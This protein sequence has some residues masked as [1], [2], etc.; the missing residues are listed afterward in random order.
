MQERRTRHG[1]SDTKK[2]SHRAEGHGTRRGH[3]LA[4]APRRGRTPPPITMSCRTIPPPDHDAVLIT[5]WD[6]VGGARDGSTSPPPPRRRRRPPQTPRRDAA[7]G[8]G[9]KRGRSSRRARLDVPSMA[10]SDS[11]GVPEH[12]AALGGRVSEGPR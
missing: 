7:A 11:G 3:E 6:D 1:P 9:G 2:R 5:A 10:A 12:S 4:G 8:E